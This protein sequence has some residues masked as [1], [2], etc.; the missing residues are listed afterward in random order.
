MNNVIT[1][2]QHDASAKLVRESFRVA[3]GGMPRDVTVTVKTPEGDPGA[4]LTDIATADGDVIV[5]GRESGR[6]IRYAV[7]GSVSRYCCAHSRCP[8]VVVPAGE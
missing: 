5:V 7:R 8:V 4:A 2:P 3:V 6:D 1:R